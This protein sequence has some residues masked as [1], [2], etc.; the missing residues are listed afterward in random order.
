MLTA[1]AVEPSGR[2][3]TMRTLAPPAGRGYE[4]L[5]GTGWDWDSEL[6]RIP[7]LLT[8]KMRAP[9][10]ETGGVLNGILR[11]IAP[12]VHSRTPR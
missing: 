11:T 9:S 12:P 1:V 3:E 8:E 5:T 2:F 6:E 4:Y 7:G 10:V